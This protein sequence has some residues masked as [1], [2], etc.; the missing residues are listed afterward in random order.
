MNR[1]IVFFSQCGHL[2][3]FAKNLAEVVDYYPEAIAIIL[4]PNEVY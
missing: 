2:V 1:Y 3:L 4:L